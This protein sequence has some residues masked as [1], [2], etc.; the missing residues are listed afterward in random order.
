[1]MH[2]PTCL[3]CGNPMRQLRGDGGARKRITPAGGCHRA[4]FS[5]AAP[6]HRPAAPHPTTQV[7]A[8][9]ALSAAA[10]AIA[11]A[12]Q[13]AQEAMMVAE[14]REP[15]ASTGRRQTQLPYARACG[16]FVPSSAAMCQP[17]PRPPPPVPLPP[18]PAGRAPDCAA[19][20]GR[21]RGHVHLLA[22]PR[23]LGPLR[24]LMRRQQQRHCSSCCN[25]IF[26]L[27]HTTE[28][29]F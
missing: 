14:V 24:P 26:L 17:L 8:V 1:M 23:R 4:A 3:R 18:P 7:A 21:H 13:A 9:A 16:A 20:L 19:G 12:A 6:Q 5:A 11:P 15:L 25:F 2:Q 27:H 10:M 28:K 22:L 29:N